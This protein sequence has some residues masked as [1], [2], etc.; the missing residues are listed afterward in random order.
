VTKAWWLEQYAQTF[1]AADVLVSGNRQ[2]MLV[3]GQAGKMFS[4]DT[5][6]TDKTSADA[7][8]GIACTYRSGNMTFG[9]NEPDRGIRFLYRPTTSDCTLSLSLHYNNSSTARPSAVSTDRGTGFVTDGGSSATLNMK[10]TRSALGD[11]TG[12][13]T[14][15]YAGRLDDKSSGGDR[16]LA[17]N[18]SATRPT[19]GPLTLYALSVGGVQ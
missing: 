17:V 5:G 4:F 8:T 1:A 6:D 16:H 9:A 15:S 2:K 3:G 18:I 7:S 13:A 11:S 14:C 19:D 12:V 10:L